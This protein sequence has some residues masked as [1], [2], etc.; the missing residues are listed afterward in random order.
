MAHFAE[1]TAKT[2][3]YKHDDCRNT[4]KYENVGQNIA[5]FSTKH[6]APIK[7]EKVVDAIIDSWLTQAN[8]L[9][10]ELV[11]QFRSDAGRFE[12]FNK[13]RRFSTHR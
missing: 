10:M 13:L 5:M 12:F 1:L 8:N 7:Y 9:G 6:K 2:C 4:E 11:E 3:E